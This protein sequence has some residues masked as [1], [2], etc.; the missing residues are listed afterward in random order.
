MHQEHS[1]D[2]RALGLVLI[3]LSWESVVYFLDDIVILGRS[4]ED[5]MKNM[6]QVEQ[7]SS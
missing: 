1:V 2:C 3:G 4:F 7:I 5:H 6:E